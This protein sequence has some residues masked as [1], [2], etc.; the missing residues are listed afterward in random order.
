LKNLQFLAVSGRIN[1]R[2]G[3]GLVR[4]TLEDGAIREFESL[5]EAA[6]NYKG[7]NVKTY[8]FRDKGNARDGQQF[9]VIA[10]L[11]PNAE[12]D[13]AWFIRFEDGGEAI[14][15]ADQVDEYLRTREAVDAMIEHH[16]PNR[17]MVFYPDG[18]DQRIAAVEDAD[19]N[20]WRIWSDGASEYYAR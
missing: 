7:D 13:D 17:L 5:D 10:Y 12:H 6:R 16:I 20:M 2:T 15:T 3:R 4:V 18:G 14:A 11:E 19:G 9:R 1:A 8:T